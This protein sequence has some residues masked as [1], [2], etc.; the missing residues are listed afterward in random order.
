MD[1]EYYEMETLEDSSESFDRLKKHAQKKV[2]VNFTNW[3][4][5]EVPS[6]NKFILYKLDLLKRAA[7]IPVSVEII[8]KEVLEIKFYAEN[9]RLDFEDINKMIGIQ[10]RQ[11][12][13]Q[14]I[15]KMLRFFDEHTLVKGKKEKRI[16]KVFNY[17]I[18]YYTF[19]L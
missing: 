4:F 8:Q 10:I 7:C 11:F 5:E 14:S 18:P 1:D 6:E 9:T 3:R 13:C 15:D 16:K 17:S 2:P 12:T 19:I